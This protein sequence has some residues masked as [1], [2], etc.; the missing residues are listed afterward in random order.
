FVA[1]VI[2]FSGGHWP[3]SEGA[4]ASTVTPA[5]A[6]IRTLRISLSPRFERMF[7]REVSTGA[8]IP[9]N[10]SLRKYPLAPE[11]IAAS[12]AANL[13]AF[14]SARSADGSIAKGASNL[15]EPILSESANHSSLLP[16]GQSV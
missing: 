6:A 3:A 12:Y 15:K 9:A 5:M 8:N 7:R 2:T 13:G 11:F 16:V 1:S 4:A 10:E 14:S